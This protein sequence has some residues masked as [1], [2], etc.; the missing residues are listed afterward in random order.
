MYM[1]VYTEKIIIC[2][3]KFASYPIKHHLI[4]IITT[5]DALP[6]R[7]RMMKE[8]K[9]IILLQLHTIYNNKH[10]YVLMVGIKTINIIVWN[11]MNTIT[12]EINRIRLVS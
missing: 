10:I 6:Q 7:K 3:D 4:S 2:T 8:S 9:Y 12:I 11:I 1:K 5:N